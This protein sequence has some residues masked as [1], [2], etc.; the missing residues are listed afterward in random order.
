MRRSW[1]RESRDFKRAAKTFFERCKTALMDC[2][3]YP[4]SFPYSFDIDACSFFCWGAEDG[5]LGVKMKEYFWD[6]TSLSPGREVV[7]IKL[8]SVERNAAISG[9]SA[10]EKVFEV[11]REHDVFFGFGFGDD[12][13]VVARGET[14]ESLLVKSDLEDL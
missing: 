10:L 5:R 3:D 8:E 14:L 1:P 13:R 6:L 11:A 12:N 2:M 7:F 4:S 9:G